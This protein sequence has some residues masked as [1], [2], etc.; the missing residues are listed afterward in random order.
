MAAPFPT[1]APANLPAGENFNFTHTSEAPEIIPTNEGG[2]GTRTRYEISPLLSGVFVP[3]RLQNMTSFLTTETLGFEVAGEWTASQATIAL[4]ST[5]TTAGAF[6][7]EVTPTSG[8]CTLT[9]QLL[10]T[11][12]F[13]GAGSNLALDFFKAGN[14]T[15]PYYDGS[16][17]L[18]ISIPSAGLNSVPL[19]QTDI[20]PLPAAAFSTVKFA[21]PAA[22]STALQGMHSDVTVEIALNV[23][24]GTGPYFFDNLRLTN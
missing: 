2:D 21:L 3:V 17:A 23:N 7:L 8:Y 1:N 10:S 9:S 12:G 11:L 15:N 16:I 14:Q 20:L 5:P 6:S 19:G 22:V 4:A 13:G 24:S 18:F